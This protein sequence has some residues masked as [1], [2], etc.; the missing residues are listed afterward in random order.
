MSPQRTQ[1]QQ[2]YLSCRILFGHQSPQCL[3][4]FLRAFLLTREEPKSLL[5]SLKNAHGAQID[6][7]SIFRLHITY[8]HWYQWYSYFFLVKHH[9]LKISTPEQP[10]MKLNPEQ[11][12]MTGRRA[13]FQSQAGQFRK[14][15]S[16]YTLKIQ[17]IKLI[18]LA[19][20]F[21]VSYRVFKITKFVK[22]HS[23]LL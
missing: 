8:N 6:Q 18:E 23:S 21:H 22:I 12:E 4:Q 1:H 5:E 7:T 14:I 3:L 2:D 10:L 16:I 17:Q 15:S 20:S 19:K 11:H 9:F 13:E